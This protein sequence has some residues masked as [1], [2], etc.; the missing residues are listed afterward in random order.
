MKNIG[1]IIK[2]IFSLAFL[3]VLLF[4]MP[5]IARADDELARVTLD[6]NG[7]T[8][9]INFFDVAINSPY[10]D[11]PLPLKDDN[12]FLGWFTSLDGGEK[13]ESED[14]CTGDITL[15]AHWTD[16]AP[17]TILYKAE[18][19]Y[20]TNRYTVLERETRSGKINSYTPSNYGK[21]FP[22]LKLKNTS[23][24][25]I[26]ADG[27]TEVDVV[28]TRNSYNLKWDLNGGEYD[29]YNEYSIGTTKYGARIYAP[30][31]KRKGFT[32]KGWNPSFNGYM[33]PEDT[34]YVAIWEGETVSYNVYYELENSTG[35]YKKDK[36]L[37]L[38]APAG[39]EVTP[40]VLYY[41]GFKSPKA[42]TITIKGDGRSYVRYQYA[43][44]SYKLTWDFNGGT[45]SGEYTPAGL[46]KYQSEIKKPSLNKEGYVFT[47]WNE[48]ISYMPAYNLTLKAKFNEKYKVEHYK[49]LLNGS[50]DS[51][52]DEIDNLNA[53]TGATVTPAVKTYTG[54]TSPTKQSVKI[55]SN[56]TT[57]I[58]YYYERN[59]YKL[60]WDFDGGRPNGSYTAEGT[61]K[62][63][64]RIEK[65]YSVTKNGF[66][67]TGFDSKL[68]N[69]PAYDLTIK[70]T[71]SEKYK[72]EHYKQ[73]VDGSYSYTPD[74]TD[75][76]YAKTGTRVSP[77]VKSY[78]GFKSPEKQ[79]VTLEGDG[80]TVIR[81]YYERYFYTLSWDFAGGTASSDYTSGGSYRYG[82]PIE[83]PTLEKPGFEFTG[84]NENVTTM[85]AKNITLK[86]LYKENK[87]PHYKVEHYKEKLDGTYSSTPDEIDDYQEKAGVN[88]T[89]GLNIY[90]GFTSPSP[91]TVVV[92]ADGSSV[93]KY[94]Y[95]R[96]SYNLAWGFNNGSASGEYAIGLVKY[97]TPIIAPT[98][99]REGY[100]F[101]GW[102][103]EI[104]AN[105]PS[106]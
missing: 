34:T 94:Y 96:N 12:N 62:Y 100:T 30:N 84:W 82:T 3:F 71:Y 104:P 5:F 15:Y 70:A 9:K 48:N 99:I 91:E 29:G 85:P 92:K 8:C 37:T 40:E 54:F 43:R 64:Q 18:L 16:E 22:G 25:K 89:P 93:V 23:I 19:A 88:V 28:Y 2:S 26:K 81:Y 58:K 86:A 10:G 38:Y 67:F 50:Y 44:N 63:D 59:S 61:Y 101:D 68:T 103:S 27:S 78:T 72:V 13:I 69:M 42:Q 14:L 66:S 1:K 80:K 4:F 32:F 36:T 7:G 105:M 46:V 95:T 17:F 45:A 11:I 97:E 24:A 55:D 53:K 39:S 74:L 31:V 75:E 57:V 21:T 20:D 35:G 60:S 79:T 49:Q 56:G 52:P 87:N 47:G 6:S 51:T 102:D 83:K 90:E 106:H 65:P 76:F 73:N 33:P 77:N 41:E 98:L